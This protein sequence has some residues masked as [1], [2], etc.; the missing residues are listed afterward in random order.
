MPDHKTGERALTYAEK[1]VRA[2]ELRRE[3]KDFRHIA[4]ELG[5]KSH[6]SAYEAVVKGL[7]ETMQEPADELR[8]VESERL[9][10]LWRK[11]EERMDTDHLW[12]V[13]RGLKVMERRASLFG[14][15]RVPERDLSREADAFLSGVHTVKQMQG[16]KDLSE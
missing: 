14:L 4:R 12:A 11:V 1:K 2:L 5:W 9:D 16:A 10:W 3:G 7:R 15:D 6:T 8:K 13:D